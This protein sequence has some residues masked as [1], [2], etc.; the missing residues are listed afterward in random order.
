M[1]DFH[2]LCLIFP[3]ADE[4][5]LEE[6]ADDIR[7]NGLNDPIV[8]HE[9]KILDGR[10]RYLACL[11]AGVEPTFADYRGDEPLEYVVTKNLHRRHL[12]P[13]QLSVAAQKVYQLAQEDDSIPE[14]EKPTQKEI[15]K[16][17]NVSER[18]LNSAVKVAES[19]SPEV[20]QKIADG[21]IT[22]HAAAEALEQAKANA[23]IKAQKKILPE[24]K[25][26]V[27]REQERILQTTAEQKKRQKSQREKTAPTP[28]PQRFEQELFEV[29][30]Q[31]P[32]YDKFD[33]ERLRE[34]TSGIRRI[35]TDLECL[36]NLFND[37]LEL[38]STLEQKA[39]LKAMLEMAIKNIG[40]MTGNIISPKT[41][42]KKLQ[43][44][45][46]SMTYG[47]IDIPDS[48]EIEKSAEERR[49]DD[50]RHKLRCSCDE[51]VRQA[52]ELHK[53]LFG[54]VVKNDG[55]DDAEYAAEE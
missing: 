27:Q 40:K 4:R 51:A 14:E 9:G 44:I 34:N 30:G 33:E 45:V 24:E 16:Q 21:D 42:K 17:F 3:Q 36:P 55:P 11:K 47:K 39:T 38:V 41:D 29:P 32:L 43:R 35:L 19:S 7:K 5:T 12:T 26:T 25:E 53:K 1:M 46:H 13:S 15:A 37:S 52:K 6:M 31:L 49:M 23:G 10:N 8:Q 22:V 20:V 28:E 54:K 18:T 2:R 48:S 50:L